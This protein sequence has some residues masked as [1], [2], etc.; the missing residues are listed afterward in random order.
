MYKKSKTDGYLISTDQSYKENLF[1]IF[2]RKT[3]NHLGTF[4][5]PKT[6]NT[7]GITITSKSFKNFP[8]GAFY[9]VND[10]SNVAAF[11]WQIIAKNLNLN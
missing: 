9:A 2:D 8:Q 7:D 6:K 4:Q 10:D 11:N 1:H 5:G 3:L